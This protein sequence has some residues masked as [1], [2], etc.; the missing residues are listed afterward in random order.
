MTD[1]ILPHSREAEE[2]VIGS[3]LIDPQAIYTVMPIIQ[4]E[5]MYLLRNREI[6]E[7][8]Y[9]LSEN[10]KPVDITTVSDQLT[11]DGKDVDSSYLTGIIGSAYSSLNVEEYC[12]T[13]K[14]YSIR[15][16]S[17]I[18]A[19]KIASGAMNISA[20]FDPN[21]FANEL[22]I[23]REKPAC[24]TFE[25]AMGLYI[26]WQLKRAANKSEL[27]GYSGGLAAIDALTDGYEPGTTTILFGEPGLGKSILADQQAKE[28]QVKYGGVIIYTLE[29]KATMILNR[30]LSCI[31]RVYTH[32]MKRGDMDELQQRDLGKAIGWMENNCRIDI[33]EDQSMTTSKIRADILHRRATGKDVN[34]IVV[35]YVGLLADP[36]RKGEDELDR[37][38][39]V[40]KTMVKIGKELNVATMLVH[41]LN[42]DNQMAGR[43]GILYSCDNALYM[44]RDKDF[45]DDNEGRRHVIIECRKV[46]DQSAEG[47]GKSRLIRS[48]HFPEFKDV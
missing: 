40:V 30:Y 27:S 47:S 37:Q 14:D 9:T 6:L 45:G 21:D 35:D 42:K 32:H 11:R 19:N 33:V 46:R 41:T 13:I 3:I 8:M 38:E 48:E 17:L 31:S 26:D 36:I 1:A 29:I 34:F 5:D 18:V 15:R 23:V 28:I 12:N 22:V 20:P 2:A 10:G 4:P 25:D 16:K 44:Y 24:S 7:S 39:R 43:M